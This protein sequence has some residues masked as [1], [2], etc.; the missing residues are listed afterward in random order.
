MAT[1]R[2]QEHSVRSSTERFQARETA[3]GRVRW[4]ATGR[5]QRLIGSS[6]LQR[7]GRPNASGQDVISVRSV[8]EKRDF[9]P[10]GYFLSGAYKYTPNRPFEQ[11][12]AEETYQEC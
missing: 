3:T 5:W 8:A 2:T 11:S 6:R 12:G 1:D 4:Q 9:V 7:S 10:N